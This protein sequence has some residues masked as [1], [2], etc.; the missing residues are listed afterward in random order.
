MKKILLFII[1]LFTFVSAVTQLQSQGERNYPII[2]NHTSIKLTQI[3][4]S[5]VTKAKEHL[6]ILYGH[7]SHGSQITSGISILRSIP[8]SIFTYNNGEGSLD[9]KE[10]GG[11]LG[12]PNRTEWANRT[13]V[14]LESESND[15]NMIVWSWCGQASSASEED[16][17]TYLTLMDELEKD[18]P[19]VVFVYMTGHLDGTGVDGNL[20]QRNEQIRNFCKKNNKILFDFADIESYDPDGNYYL[21][22]GANDGC[23]YYDENHNRKNWADEWCQKNPEMCASCGCAHSK[24]LNCQMKGIAFWWMLAQ[25]EG[26]DGGIIEDVDE[27]TVPGFDLQI[28]PNPS[29]D[30]INLYMDLPESGDVNYVIYDISGLKITAGNLGNFSKG[31]YPAII[32]VSELSAGNYFIRLVTAGNWLTKSFVKVK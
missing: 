30:F 27:N 8:N 9:Y 18:F 26:W 28:S 17:N 14:Q 7:T 24:C 31:Y 3:P 22:K 6:K 5:Y 29:K 15:R 25:I 10:R 4:E 21:D 32:D 13:R 19:E 12:N 2:A 20:N 1:V 11:D 23:Y 16:I